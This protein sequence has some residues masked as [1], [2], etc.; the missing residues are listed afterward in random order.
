MAFKLVAPMAVAA[1]CKTLWASWAA[2][3]QAI[4]ACTAQKANSLCLMTPLYAI[5]AT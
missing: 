3:V 2:A 5:T 1:A 4:N